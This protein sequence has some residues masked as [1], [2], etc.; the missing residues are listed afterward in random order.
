MRGWIADEAIA[1]EMAD[2]IDVIIGGASRFNRLDETTKYR[3]SQ[4]YSPEPV[5]NALR[6]AEGAVLG[7]DRR[8]ALFKQ[9]LQYVAKG[10]P[11]IFENFFKHVNEQAQLV[12]DE[13]FVACFNSDVVIARYKNSFELEEELR[14]SRSRDVERE[15][16]AG[17]VG[18]LSGGEGWRD[19][20][21]TRKAKGTAGY[22]VGR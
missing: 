9:L 18:G 19:R 16:A 13:V 15:G 14:S 3:I 10:R 6:D 5:I 8:L 12:S 20:N 7:A 2:A 17:G 1:K 11:T 21:A 22:S 4:C